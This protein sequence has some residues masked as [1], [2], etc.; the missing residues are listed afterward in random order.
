MGISKITAI[1]I[2]LAYPED[3]IMINAG[4]SEEKYAGYMYRLNED[5]TIHK[6]LISTQPVFKSE[7]EAEDA[8]KDIAEQCVKMEI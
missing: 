7:Q 3:L 5:K 1:E 2:K 8:M 4:G 6:I